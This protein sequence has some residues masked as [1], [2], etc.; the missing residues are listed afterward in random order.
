MD[1][2]RVLG[3]RVP[4][5]VAVVGFDGI[6]FA[7]MSNP[8]LTT[9]VTPLTELGRLAASSLVDAIR[10]GQ[11]P[12]AVVLPVELAIRESTRSRVSQAAGGGAHD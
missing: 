12:E 5:D 6:P 4:D 1:A 2:L 10:S 7:E 8:R 9:V 11:L 3:V